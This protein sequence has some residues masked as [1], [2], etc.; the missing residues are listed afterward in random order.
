LEVDRAQSSLVNGLPG[1]ILS[2]PEDRCALC[3]SRS[4]EFSRPAASV[5]AL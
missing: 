2:P 5:V 1:A 4:C 3:D